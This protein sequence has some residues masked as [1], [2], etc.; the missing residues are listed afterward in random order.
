MYAFA[1]TVGTSVFVLML[2]WLDVVKPVSAFVAVAII[3]GL[4]LLSIF[5]GWQ[6]PVPVDL[7]PW[8]ARAV[9]ASIRQAAGRIGASMPD[10]PDDPRKPLPAM[11]GRRA[12]SRKARPP[13]GPGVT[14]PGP[15]EAGG[16]EPPTAGEDDAGDPDSTT[17]GAGKD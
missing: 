3:L 2:V 9:P 17:P 5:L 4:R 13:D 1:A 16:S 11:V 7:T 8:I 15:G 6:T 12:R 10:L 14:G